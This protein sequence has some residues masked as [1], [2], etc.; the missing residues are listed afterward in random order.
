MQRAASNF[1]SGGKKGL[2]LD[3]VNATAD[4][5]HAL[6]S[7]A[8]NALSPTLVWFDI[9]PEVCLARAQQRT[10]H[11]LPPGGRVRAA[12]KQ[13]TEQWEQ[14]QMDEGWKAIVRVTSVE[15]ASELARRWTPASA[16]GWLKFPRTPH[17]VNLGAATEDDEIVTRP[18][19]AGDDE[20]MVVT[21]KLDGANMGFSLD[22]EG[23]V[24]VQNRSHYVDEGAHVQFKR[25]GL[26]VEEHREE[27]F[28][29]LGRDANWPGRY[30]LYGEWM[31]AVHS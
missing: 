4:K 22:D 6:L 23:K 5:R 30:I 15:A 1:R 17:L 3:Q 8:H 28:A 31:A 21:E 18:L 11:S 19:R 9:P 16:S 26:W 29:L 20:R 13:F 12:I 25:L 14:P 27:L 10:G 24:V 2:I 7:L